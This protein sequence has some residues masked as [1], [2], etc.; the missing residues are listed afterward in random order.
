MISE[1]S[2]KFPQ[3]SHLKFYSHYHKF[4]TLKQ[5]FSFRCKW[6]F[7]FDN[8]LKIFWLISWIMNWLIVLGDLWENFQNLKTFSI[9]LVRSYYLKNFIFLLNAHPTKWEYQ[10]TTLRAV[11][12]PINHVYYIIRSLFFHQRPIMELLFCLWHT[13]SSYDQKEVKR[14][15]LVLTMWF[16][17]SFER[18]YEMLACYLGKCCRFLYSTPLVP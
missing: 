2:W 16:I 15:I 7:L 18:N 10:I 13:S 4:S 5:L 17:K 3:C 6:I 8:Y 9:Q 1:I 14:S 12:R 11:V